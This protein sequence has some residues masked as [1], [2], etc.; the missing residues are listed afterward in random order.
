MQ[1]A[2]GT[3]STREIELKSINGRNATPDELNDPEISIELGAK[4]LGYL[5]DKYDGDEKKV[6]LAYNQGE[7]NTDRGKDYTPRYNSEGVSYSVKFQR[8]KKRILS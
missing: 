8:H 7:K 1:I 4:L 6:S 2:P 3:G 5:W